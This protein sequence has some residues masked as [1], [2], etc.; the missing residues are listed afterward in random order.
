VTYYRQDGI[1]VTDHW[2]TVNGYRFAIADLH[3]L[4]TARGA[5]S[6]FTSNA[7]IAAVVVAAGVA[8]AAGFLGTAGR[9]GAGAVL[10]VTLSLVAVGLLRRPRPFELWAMH[11][12]GMVQLLRVYNGQRFRQICRALLRA[13]ERFRY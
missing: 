11:R 6:R 9:L 5:R 12:G 4:R 3:H 8:V 10:A 1:N 7:S 2:L 13:Q